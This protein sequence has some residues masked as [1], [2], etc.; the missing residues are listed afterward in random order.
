MDNRQSPNF[1]NVS[2]IDPFAD[3]RW[4][5]VLE[6]DPDGSIFHHPAWLQALHDTYGYSPVCLMATEG[7]S[8][9]GILPLM[10]VRSWVTGNRAVCLPFS[11]TCGPVARDET[12]RRALLQHAGELKQQRK[13]KYLEIRDSTIP[14][15]FGPSARYKLHRSELGKDPDALLRTL[16]QHSRR[17]LKKAQSS[18]VRVERRTD[19][20][21]LRAFIRL[22]ALTRRKHGMLP[23]PDSFFRNIQKRILDAGL[24]FIGAATLDG[25]IVATNVFLHWSKTVVYKYGASDDRA[26]SAGANYA[27]MWDAMR[28]S[29]EH[30]F[31]AFDFGRTDLHGEGL[32]QFKRGWGSLESDLVYARLSDAPAEPRDDAPG[33]QERLKP[34]ISMMPVPILKLLGGKAYPHVG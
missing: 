11:D 12:A 10:E 18:G 1:V 9:A 32:L 29:C 13:W 19:D 8:C 14:A 31:S 21:A 25:Q 7:D 24:G 17:K 15:G 20:E 4:L 33:L 22:N 28:W 27:V 3:P 23:Q 6:D 34:V 16:N 2:P 30:G 5:K 26:L